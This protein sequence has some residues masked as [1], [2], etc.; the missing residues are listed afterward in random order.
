MP[1]LLLPQ[2]QSLGCS[3]G[4][5]CRGEGLQNKAIFFK[6]RS[7][8][9]AEQGAKGM[10]HCC[11]KVKALGNICRIIHVSLAQSLPLR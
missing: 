3:V 4:S 9:L 6:G 1:H 7:P 8:F 11:P 10:L 2:S 5:G